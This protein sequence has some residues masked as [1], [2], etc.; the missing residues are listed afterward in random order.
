MTPLRPNKPSATIYQ[1]CSAVGSDLVPVLWIVAGRILS[2][3][4]LGWTLLSPFLMIW[5][6][7]IVTL[8]EILGLLDWAM[9]RR[10]RQELAPDWFSG[11]DRPLGAPP[12]LAM[13]EGSGELA[14][15]LEAR[16]ARW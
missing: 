2:M 12:L 14:E 10:D 3:S 8:L 4:R 11:P 16:Q 13:D 5:G 15:T 6:L 1:P 7:A 9:G